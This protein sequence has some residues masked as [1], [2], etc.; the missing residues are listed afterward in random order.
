MT[1]KLRIKPT[2]DKFTSVPNII[3]DMGLS[4]YA[5]RLYMR[6][7]R[8]AGDVGG[9]C[10]ENTNNLA[11]GC[12][13]S[14]GSVVKAKKELQK[15]GLIQ[16]EAKENPHGGKPYH[17]ISVVDIWVLNSKYYPNSS[18]ELASSP[19][20]VKKNPLRKGKGKKKMASR[21]LPPIPPQAEKTSASDGNNSHAT[22]STNSQKNHPAIRAI[23]EITGYYPPK[24][25]YEPI[26]NLLGD[27]PDK[28][29][30]R[31][32]FTIW[33]ANGYNARNYNGWLFDRYATESYY[34]NPADK[35][36]L[37]YI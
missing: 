7:K 2:R 32:A 4:P 14:V 6:I 10:W 16:I 22:S 35:A 9:A 24:G 34:V 17:E 28:K 19:G 5:V 30:L 23:K 29:R 33:E 1:E 25:L 31:Q 20:E 11:T 18:G 12:R 13:M 26:I 15:A 27:E 8:R 21:S 37:E 3:D 36:V